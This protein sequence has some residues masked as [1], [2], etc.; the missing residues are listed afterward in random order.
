MEAQSKMMS[1][2]PLH[3]ELSTN[4]VPLYLLMECRTLLSEPEWAKGQTGT[5]PKSAR[6]LG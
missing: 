2:L 3:K 1:L 5:R 6:K 4:C